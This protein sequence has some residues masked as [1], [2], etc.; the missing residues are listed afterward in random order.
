MKEIFNN[1]AFRSTLVYLS[2]TK[3]HF[4][5]LVRPKEQKDFCLS[6]KLSLK[7]EFELQS[8]PFSVPHTFFS[9]FTVVVPLPHQYH[10]FSCFL[11]LFFC[12]FNKV[13]IQ[14]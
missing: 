7:V 12:I 5:F 6:V 9:L 11:S 14:F 2:I 4:G 1:L 3:K 10:F 8:A 13:D